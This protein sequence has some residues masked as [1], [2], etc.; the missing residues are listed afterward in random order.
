MYCLA[1]TS[2]K[3]NDKTTMASTPISIIPKFLWKH[4]IDF[5]SITDLLCMNAVNKFFSN[6]I[7]DADWKKCFLDK[8]SHDIAFVICDSKHM[9]NFWK[10]ACRTYI[11]CSN[12][13]HA[14]HKIEQDNRN[15]SRFN[16]KQQATGRYIYYKIFIKPGN[17]DLAYYNPQETRIL[18][19]FTA[20]DCSIEMIGSKSCMGKTVLTTHHELGAMSVRNGQR[21]MIV[22]PQHFL[23]KNITFGNFASGLDKYGFDTDNDN[24]TILSELHILN[25]TFNNATLFE[26]KSINKVTITNC[27]F[28]HR[29]IL[30]FSEADDMLADIDT[31]SHQYIISH[32]TF[33]HNNLTL[34]VPTSCICFDASYDK[35][36]TIS[37]FDNTVIQSNLL[38]AYN[39]KHATILFEN[40]V[41]E[42]GAILNKKREKLNHSADHT[43]SDSSDP[44]NS[45]DS[46]AD[47]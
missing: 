21:N 5:M 3:I 24:M 25:C 14:F 33:S 39:I 1:Y 12:I 38:C 17:Y 45:S 13:D 36:T 15:N 44:D 28:N 7:N 4:I 35:F 46:D 32:N 31:V 23:I 22:C 18:H 19:L 34:D 10:H 16:E 43:G 20:T 26:I 2:N 29:N 47:M 27:A 40:N 30:Y 9:D 6:V 41:D 8:K 11:N 37:I 42:H